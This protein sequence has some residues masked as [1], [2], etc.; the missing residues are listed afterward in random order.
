MKGWKKNNM[1]YFLYKK[2]W[3]ELISFYNTPK[4]QWK[5]LRIQT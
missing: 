5:K 4:T 2:D 3:Q 1:G